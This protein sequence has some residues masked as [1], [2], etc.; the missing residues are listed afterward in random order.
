MRRNDVWQKT[1]SKLSKR[2]PVKTSHASKGLPGRLQGQRL[3]APADAEKALQG[4]PGS[5]SA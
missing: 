3:P 2:D 1:G 5:E 4:A